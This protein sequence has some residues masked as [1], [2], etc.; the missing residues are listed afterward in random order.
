[1]GGATAF[2]VCDILHCLPRS[3]GVATVEVPL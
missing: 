1:M 3:F 2:V